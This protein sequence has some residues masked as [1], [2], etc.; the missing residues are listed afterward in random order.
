MLVIALLVTHPAAQPAA[1]LP[2]L[3]YKVVRSYPHDANA[4][5]QGLEIV[6]GRLYEGTGLEGRSSI[7]RVKSK[8]G[9][10]S[11]NS[12]SRGSIRRR[13]H[14]F[15]GKM[16]QLTWQSGVAFVYD[17]KT[18]RECGRSPIPVKDGV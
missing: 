8:T 7:R 5:T 3:G 12:I 1:T 6:N 15:G 13:D 2:L 10:S 18:F 4:F 9:K 11:R 16:F 17:P 14:A